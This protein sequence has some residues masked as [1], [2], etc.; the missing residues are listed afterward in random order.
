MQVQ[1]AVFTG[2]PDPGVDEL[3]QKVG[4]CGICGSDLHAVE[5]GFV[6]VGMVMG[7]EFAGELVAVGAG[8]EDAYQ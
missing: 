6:S 8:A 7:H 4:A 3:L 5:S 1:A 2:Q